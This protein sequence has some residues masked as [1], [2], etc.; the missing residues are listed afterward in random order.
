VRCVKKQEVIESGSSNVIQK[1]TL[2]G[3]SGNVTVRKQREAKANAKGKER[4]E[5][6]F[7]PASDDSDRNECCMVYIAAHK[8]GSSL[9]DA[10]HVCDGL[11]P[12]ELYM[13]CSGCGT[14]LT[15]TQLIDR[16]Y[17]YPDPPLRVMRSMMADLNRDHFWV[18]PAAPVP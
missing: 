17:F 15:V 7:L 13:S 16:Y 10:R 8:R 9:W 11:M 3:T 1:L 18:R 5:C 6:L 2:L 14:L 12:S 4:G